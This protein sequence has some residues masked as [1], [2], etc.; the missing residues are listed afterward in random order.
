MT[1]GMTYLPHSPNVNYNWFEHKER[2]KVFPINA[3]TQPE[4]EVLSYSST[5]AH[6]NTKSKAERSKGAWLV[7]E[8]KKKSLFVHMEWESE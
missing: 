3:A 6:S 7:S 5:V 4:L 8:K 2:P 1:T